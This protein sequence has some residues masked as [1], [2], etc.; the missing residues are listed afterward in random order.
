M[1]NTMTTD[2]DLNTLVYNYYNEIKERKSNQKSNEISDFVSELNYEEVANR[3]LLIDENEYK[4]PVFVE[5]DDEAA[6][7]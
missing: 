1:L 4:L 6:R 2:S 3:F 5:F 7:I